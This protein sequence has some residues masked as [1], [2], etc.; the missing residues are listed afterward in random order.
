MK[1]SIGSGVCPRH[2]DIGA[3]DASFGWE[4]NHQGS[5]EKDMSVGCKIE[6][7]HKSNQDLGFLLNWKLGI[8][9]TINRDCIA[10]Y[11][12]EVFDWAKFFGC[13]RC[14]F[15]PFKREVLL[16]GGIRWVESIIERSLIELKEPRA[17]V[18]VGL[19]P[20]DTVLF[21]GGWKR[22]CKLGVMVF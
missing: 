15:V 21:T 5:I 11:G 10:F 20:Y 14:W 13:T 7:R 8:E 3:T 4:W 19:C 18:Q 17:Q 16:C 22:V 6:V 9:M 1:R 2:D 12:N